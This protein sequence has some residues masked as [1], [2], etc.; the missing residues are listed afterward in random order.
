MFNT[1]P[2]INLHA[3]AGTRVKTQSWG[4]R[5]E[6]NDVIAFSLPRHLGVEHPSE[7]SYQNHLFTVLIFKITFLIFT[8]SEHSMY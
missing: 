6:G 5:F 4:T 3:I 1:E 8:Y 2:A 7:V